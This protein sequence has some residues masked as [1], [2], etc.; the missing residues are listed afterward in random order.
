MLMARVQRTEISRLDE[1]ERLATGAIRVP[2][3]PT[4]VG[5][6]EYSDAAGKTW[7]EYRPAEEVFAPD[8]L[9]SLRSST[10]TDLH[11]DPAAYPAGVTAQNWNDLAVGHVGDDVRPAGEFVAVS[12]LVQDAA[13]VAMV[14]AGTRRELS[15]GYTCDVDPTP[16]TTPAGEAYDAVQRN[17]RYNHVALGP[18]GW[19]RAGSECALRLDGGNAVHHRPAAIQK[20][21]PATQK[22]TDAAANAQPT[23]THVHTP[24]ADARAPE[25]SMQKSLKIKGREFKLDAD[26]DIA[27]AQ[28]A[29]DKMQ[30]DADTELAA[31]KAALMDALTKLATYEAKQIASGAAGGGADTTS[32]DPAEI[33][34]AVM[35]AAIEKREALRALAKEHGVDVNG[36]KHGDAV[37]AVVLKA[38]PSVKKD[39]SSEVIATLFDAARDA[40]ATKTDAKDVRNDDLAAAN[41]VA[42][43]IGNERRDAAEDDD[44]FTQM[45]RKSENRWRGETATKGS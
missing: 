17:I 35:D 18:S 24:R 2:A 8:S 12:V 42:A 32:T 3:T 14:D 20:T 37:K 44:P 27:T 16:G 39:A 4:R 11:P 43:G 5:V 9:T 26:G 29:V 33:P 6:L 25:Q 22:Q 34:D 15:C 30:Q 38:F 23:S 1:I 7:R 21:P 10:L 28:G 19:G 13:E 45:Q 40:K 36:M 41:R 31:I